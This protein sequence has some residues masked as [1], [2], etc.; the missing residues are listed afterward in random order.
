ML[1]AVSKILSANQH[2]EQRLQSA[3]SKL[4]QQAEQIRVH[5]ANALTDALTG[6][7]NRRAFDSELARRLAEFQRYGKTF[8]LMMLDID[9]FKRFN[10]THGHLAGDQVLRLVG[11]T[12]K[13]T[14]R[15]PDFVARYGGEEFAV[16][17]PQTS[18]EEGSRGG[19][20]IRSGI[21]RA[22]CIYENKNLQVTASIGL[23]KWAQ[24]KARRS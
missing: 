16:I 19:E 23:C 12:L 9:H 17:M 18:L 8:C 4:Q 1:D 14:V 2:L 11:A 24:A 10:D 6:L 15:T 3:E 20:R 22:K 13:T 5:A 7:A 21:E